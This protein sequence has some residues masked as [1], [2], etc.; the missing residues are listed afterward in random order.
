MPIPTPVC[1]SELAR[2]YYTQRASAGLIFTEGHQ[3]FADGRGLCRNR[4]ASGPEEQ[5]QGWKKITDAVHAKGGRIVLQL[6]HVGRISHPMFLNGAV[7]E[8]PSA[9]QTQRP[10]RQPGAA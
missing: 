2:I 10:L 4:P 7:P 9:V 6:W 3:R 5:T 8:A 1:P